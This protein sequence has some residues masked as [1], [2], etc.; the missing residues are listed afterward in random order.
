MNVRPSSRAIAKKCAGFTLAEIAIA[1]VIVGLLLASAFL[2]LSAQMELRNISDTQ[3]TMDAIREAIIGFAQ[4]NGRLPCPANGST[5]TGA[6]TAGVE[7][8][9][10]NFCTAAADGLG[11]HGVVPWA[12][13][14][15][16]E[17]DA[18]GRRFSYRVS[19][20]YADLNAASSWETLTTNTPASAGNQNPGGP[21]LPCAPSPAPVTPTSFALCTV[22]D[23]AVFSPTAAT[24]TASP[25]AAIAK[26]VP[27][28]IVSHGKNGYGAFQAVSGL[29]SVSPTGVHELRNV[30]GTPTATPTG[31][32]ASYAYYSRIQT[33]QAT[34]CSDTAVGAS[35]FCEFD[36]VVAWI[37]P[38][39]LVTR[40]VSAGRLP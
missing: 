29:Q 33:T 35:P 40:M 12:T 27:A 9:T 18:W 14:G 34:T 1:M 28:I 6:A 5:A 31:W 17:S 7:Q 37:P 8:T 24:R 21:S 10:G 2:P 38:A 15:V 36:D 32:F 20:A 22:G 16:P 19:P 26:G 3:R 23:I 25:T 39:T 11:A 4:A 30:T 13:L